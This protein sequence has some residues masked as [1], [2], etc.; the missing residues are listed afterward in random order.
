MK[1]PGVYTGRG[2]MKIV[3]GYVTENHTPRQSKSRIEFQRELS[4]STGWVR[5]RH[6]NINQRMTEAR[7]AT[8]PRRQL[9]PNT[10]GISVSGQGV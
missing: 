9:L 7:D 3:A 10:G 1:E 5:A 4:H 2:L 8:M 6:I